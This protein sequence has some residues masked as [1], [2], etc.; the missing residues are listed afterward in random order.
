MGPFA[1]WIGLAVGAYAL[2]SVSFSLLFARAQGIDL[3]A[4]GSGN[5][6]ATNAGRALGRRTG[7]LVYFLDMGKGLL[8]AWLGLHFWGPEAG[9]AG[10]T[11]AYLGHI[12]PLWL[13]FRGGKGVATLTGAMLILQPSA[14]LVSALAWFLVVR[15]TG[16]VALG[17]LVL[18]TALPASAWLLET[19]PSVR[20]FALCAGIFLFYTHRSN[21]QR[22]FA[23]K[24]KSVEE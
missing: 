16:V 14:M 12:W 15:L 19:P 7:L 2:G 6:G 21:L 9:V 17:S 1:T 11:G 4:V 18:G 8:P 5:L 3:R 23:G 22:L 13:R 10:G 20:I 24:E